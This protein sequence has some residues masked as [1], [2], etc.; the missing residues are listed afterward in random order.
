[1]R[2]IKV[3]ARSTKLMTFCDVCSHQAFSNCS[4]CYL[5]VVADTES[6]KFRLASEQFHK[7][8]NMPEEEELVN[9]KRCLG[10]FFFFLSFFLFDRFLVHHCI[11]PCILA[12]RVRTD[13]FGRYCRLHLVCCASSCRKHS[14]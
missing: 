3:G 13:V 8:F 5:H 11:H 1:M 6:S 9:C 7:D 2:D 12:W 4:L 14:V 10:A